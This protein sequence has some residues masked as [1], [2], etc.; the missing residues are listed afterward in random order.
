[1]ICLLKITDILNIYYEAN[2]NICI[3][4][5]YCTGYDGK[6]VSCTLAIFLF[7]SAFLLP[8]PRFLERLYRDFP[9]A[10]SLTDLQYLLDI[11]HTH[12]DKF[13]PWK[14]YSDLLFFLILFCFVLKAGVVA[15]VKVINFFDLEG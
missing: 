6:A 4:G 7:A 1:M 12:F 13:Y 11:T 2:H 3:V 14:T 5:N 9:L 10:F 8:R 15:I